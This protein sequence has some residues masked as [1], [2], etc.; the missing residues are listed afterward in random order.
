MSYFSLFTL[1]IQ[2]EDSYLPEDEKEPWSVR[3]VVTSVSWRSRSALFEW[4]FG[5]FNFH[6]EHHLF[7][8][9]NPSVYPK[10]QPLVKAI[11][12]RHH[13]RYK[14]ITYLELVSSQVRAWRR[15]AIGGN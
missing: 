2:H 3:Q 1:F 10:I 13:V 9:L 11:C 14:D 4:L 15:Y 8:G 7:P 6:I 5:Y 12:K